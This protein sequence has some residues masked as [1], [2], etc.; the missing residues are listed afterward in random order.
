M[1]VTR[2]PM[3]K[4]RCN[5]LGPRQYRRRLL[6]DPILKDAGLVIWLRVL[7]PHNL[8]VSMIIF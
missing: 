5:Q 6:S 8:L 1:C 3:V 7:N 4:A 2:N